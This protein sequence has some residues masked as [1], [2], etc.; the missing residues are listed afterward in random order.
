MNRINPA[1]NDL[2]PATPIVILGVPFDKLTLAEAVA[3]IEQMIATRQPHYLATA[4]VDF[5]VQALR[6][7]ELRRILYE[8]H[9]VLCDG[10]PLVWA[11]RWLGNPLPERVAGSDLVPELLKVAEQNGYRVFFLGG[12]EEIIQQALANLKINHPQLQVAGHLSPPFA[13]LLEM[14][15][16]GICQTIRAANPDLLFVS[17]GCPK[18]EKWINMNYRALNVPVAVGV[19]ATIDFLA[20]AVSRAPRWMQQAGLEWIYRLCQEPRRLVR[21]YGTDLWVFG[22]AI[23]VQW[24]Q[25]QARRRRRATA[26]AALT[27]SAVEAT[28][29]LIHVPA[30]FDAALVQEHEGLW[31]ELL[32]AP[33]SLLLDFSAVESVDS[34]GVGLVLRLQKQLRAN[35]LQLVLIAPSAVTQRTL[36]LMRL[37]NF[38][39]TAPDLAAARQLLAGAVAGAPAVVAIN[40]G[41]GLPPVVW[42]GEITAGNED[43]V[44]RLTKAVLTACA[45][46]HQAELLID[47]A[48]VRYVDS[49]GVRVMVRLRK[50]ALLH[51]VTIVFANPQPNVLNVIR[52]LRLEAYLLGEAR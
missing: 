4:N 41:P 28:A 39:E 46:K 11:T 10:T 17:F 42:L 19:G 33:R 15:H 2:R 25:L 50:L 7:V 27:V 31:N 51:R 37:A 3:V 21:R 16:A 9:M 40:L 38:V 23:L 24:W 36:K 32:A 52:M 12:K 29:S 48:Q 8:A 20:G 26:P 45:S 18:Q 47:L 34:T 1:S 44:W 14:D 35:G 30:N 22:R 6:D 5:V 43:E 49:S 13:P